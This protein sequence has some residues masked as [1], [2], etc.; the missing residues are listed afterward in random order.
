[1]K[2]LE[3]EL[4]EYASVIRTMIQHENEV[5]NHR[6]TWMLVFQGILFAAA[7]SFWKIHL[8]PFIVVGLLGISTSISFSYALWLSYNARIGLRKLWNLKIKNNE[9]I[10]EKIPPI[11]GDFGKI[12]IPIQFRFKKLHPW[13][14]I[15]QVIILCWLVMLI[16]GGIFMNK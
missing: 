6:L 8:L 7:A 11:T 12:R 3:K 1:M 10:A 16:L 2:E 4:F 5:T 9:E 14:F 13:L 15:P